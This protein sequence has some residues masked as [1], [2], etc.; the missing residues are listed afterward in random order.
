MFLFVIYFAS[1]VIREI[2]IKENPIFTYQIVEPDLWNLFSGKKKKSTVISNKCFTVQ[3]ESSLKLRF[4]FNGANTLFNVNMTNTHTHVYNVHSMFCTFD[5]TWQLSVNWFVLHHVAL[6]RTTDLSAIRVI[7]GLVQNG[8]HKIS[9]DIWKSHSLLFV[10]EILFTAFQLWKHKM[11]WYLV[12]ML[13]VLSSQW[14]VFFVI[15]WSSAMVRLFM[16]LDE[17]PAKNTRINGSLYCRWLTR[18]V[19]ELENYYC[20]MLSQ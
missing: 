19:L 14:I 10:N 4:R 9:F 16:K 20:Y 12:W 1:I 13:K 18:N 7:Y 6:Y 15:L 11:L 5:W 8:N 17:S 3:F 2:Q